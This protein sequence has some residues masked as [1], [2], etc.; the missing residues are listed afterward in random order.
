MEL[1][2]ERG[3]SLIFSFE[4]FLGMKN[5]TYDE[6]LDLS[7]LHMPAPLVNEIILFV[8]G[9]KVEEI[10]EE[11]ISKPRVV[12]PVII[13]RMHKLIRFWKLELREKEKL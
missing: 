5:T 2:T 11:L 13:K 6:E 10:F 9:D 3:E 4:V 8:Y 7:V 1:L 12:M